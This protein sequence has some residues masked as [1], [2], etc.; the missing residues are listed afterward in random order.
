MSYIDP[1]I[2]YENFEP[3]VSE[4]WTVHSL[5]KRIKLFC[6]SDSN[7]W[8]KVKKQGEGY[9]GSFRAVSQAK[10]F[11]EDKKADSLTSL[12]LLIEQAMNRNLEEWRRNRFS[13]KFDKA[14]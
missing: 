1:I 3:S 8:F 2:E 5:V 6:P 11:I 9:S 13:S 14:M 7:V 12:M 4:K 10:I